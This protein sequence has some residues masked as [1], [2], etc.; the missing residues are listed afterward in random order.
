MTMRSTTPVSCP[1]CG[2]E[3][4]FAVCQTLNA[5]LDPEL[6]EQLLSGRLTGFTCR[7]CGRQADVI[8]PMLYHDMTR[9]FMAWLVPGDQ[10]PEP[11]DAATFGETG[12]EIGR[13]YTYRLVRTH[14]Q[15]VEKIKVF[16]DG[17]DDR[18]LEML[19]TFLRHGPETITR[20]TG[21]QM[22]YDGYT[23]DT[24]GARQLRLVLLGGAEASAVNLKP[25]VYDEFMANFAAAL[26]GPASEPGQWLVV[27]ESYAVN[28]LEA[29]L[30]KQEK[31]ASN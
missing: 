28:L 18:L 19:K 15:L 14:N 13:S 5:T 1:G 22:F 8:Y 10:Q 7:S 20:E 31:A 4:E 2:Q 3:Q 11:L 27:N 24:A 9:R 30:E 21:A 29:Y 25:G 6:R 17:L 12:D 23:E 26:P 16:E